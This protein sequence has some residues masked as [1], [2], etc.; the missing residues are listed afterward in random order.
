MMMSLPCQADDVIKLSS[1]KRADFHSFTQSLHRQT[2][3]QLQQERRKNRLLKLLRNCA[4][5]MEGLA[6]KS[7]VDS[8]KSCVS[9]GSSTSSSYTS[10]FYTSQD[11]IILEDKAEL[12]ASVTASKSDVEFPQSLPRS[13]SKNLSE[14]VY[15]N[16]PH[17][18]DTAG[19]DLLYSSSDHQQRRFV[20]PILRLANSFCS[21]YVGDSDFSC[22][23]S[24]ED[25]STN[26]QVCLNG[27]TPAHGPVHSRNSRYS[28]L[29]EDDYRDLVSNGK[30]TAFLSHEEGDLSLYYDDEFDAERS[31]P[32]I[33]LHDSD[34][35]AAICNEYASLLHTAN[36][37]NKH[38][39]SINSSDNAH[40]N[41]SSDFEN[42]FPASLSLH[43]DLVDSADEEVAGSA[44]E[45]AELDG[46]VPNYADIPAST[47]GDYQLTFT[48]AGRVKF[49]GVLVEQDVPYP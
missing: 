41:F 6:S 9:F 37:L 21:S 23:K 38:N 35:E 22:T 47:K 46:S 33:P 44:E 27:K 4:D 29:N 31:P 18:M 19:E 17:T 36:A 3:E 14:I 7:Y 40:S 2:C 1:L 8:M 28:K 39:Q 25:I 10:N 45:I 43:T 13:S 32:G 48:Q 34:L 26:K 16:S 42:I 11:L 12:P 20:T 5:S 24:E 49:K 30:S 15:P